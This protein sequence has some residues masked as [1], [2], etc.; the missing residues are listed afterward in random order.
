MREIVSLLQGPAVVGPSPPAFLR[1]PNG[2]GQA[3]ALWTAAHSVSEPVLTAGPI[4]AHF[5]FFQE[6]LHEHKEKVREEGVLKSIEYALGSAQ[7]DIN[8]T[9]ASVTRFV[10]RL[11]SSIKQIRTEA[12]AAGGSQ[13]A[14]SSTSTQTGS[15][16]M[17]VGDGPK[18]A[19]GAAVGEP[20][21]ITSII[22]QQQLGGH[23]SS[24]VVPYDS[25]ASTNAPALPGTVSTAAAGAHTTSS[26]GSSSSS[27]PNSTATPQLQQQS[28]PADR[29]TEMAKELSKALGLHWTA[30][31]EVDAGKS[32]E[33]VRDAALSSLS[34]LNTTMCVLQQVQEAVVVARKAHK[35]DA[36]VKVVA[37]QAMQR[38]LNA[39]T[40]SHIAM[41]ITGEALSNAATEETN[42]LLVALKKVAQDMQKGGI[43]KK[44]LGGVAVV[45]VTSEAGHSATAVP[46]VAGQQGGGGAGASTGAGEARGPAVPGTHGGGLGGLVSAGIGTGKGQAAGAGGVS[47]AQLQQQQQQQES[48]LHGNGRVGAAPPRAMEVVASRGS[49][50]ANSGKDAE[51]VASSS[52]TNSTSTVLTGGVGMGTLPVVAAGGVTGDRTTPA[53]GNRVAGALTPA[54]HR[55]VAGGGL[56]AEAAVSATGATSSSSSSSSSALPGL[57]ALS[58]E[59]AA[60]DGSG[61]DGGSGAVLSSPSLAGST[62][63]K[64]KGS[65]SPSS[66]TTDQV[67]HI[68]QIIG[69]LADSLAGNSTSGGGG[70]ADGSSTGTNVTM[71]VSA[72]HDALVWAQGSREAVMDMIEARLGKT[73]SKVAS[74]VVGIVKDI[75]LEQTAAKSKEQQAQQQEEMAVSEAEGHLQNQQQQPETVAAGTSAPQEALKEL[76]AQQHQGEPA[77]AP[78]HQQ[79]QQVAQQGQ[80]QAVGAAAAPGD[81]D[82]PRQ[83]QSKE[84]GVRELAGGAT[85]PAVQIGGGDASGKLGTEAGRDGA[86]HVF[87]GK[88]GK[89]DGPVV[90]VTPEGKLEQSDGVVEGPVV[91]QERELVQGNRVGLGSEGSKRVDA[92][93]DVVLAGRGSEGEKVSGAAVDQE[94]KAGGKG[95]SEAGTGGPVVN[96]A[97]GG[98]LTQIEDNS[99][100]P[101]V[102]S[103]EKGNGEAL[104]SSSH[105][106]SADLSSEVSGGATKRL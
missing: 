56:A 41:K 63:G 31:G 100:G 49:T 55:A 86:A 21:S 7:E 20:G 11:D 105:S 103:I 98:Q 79:H 43:S 99:A 9:V 3:W 40:A 13:S 82:S 60:A 27:S 30:A 84:T 25:I 74:R 72:I 15:S 44:G 90:R 29:A 95:G 71:L 54:A 69:N 57:T 52:G 16:G 76:Q 93:D 102:D 47:E 92:A 6:R 61:D 19:P 101:V 80:Q 22:V 50:G 91:V 4:A 28:T 5:R 42:E 64:A 106:V 94:A 48:T 70:D 23:S 34:A 45:K 10:I 88:D 87:I 67:M 78:H 17:Q 12:A 46:A 36:Q 26:S 24:S 83:S 81:V 66:L 89:V 35:R 58:G 62:S 1:L 73:D 33:Q 18:A 38:A 39:T 51:G 77:I 32:L 104:A 53:V 85:A 75:R 59:A 96:V 14:L 8:A 97:R 37:V 2:A 68:N 65:V